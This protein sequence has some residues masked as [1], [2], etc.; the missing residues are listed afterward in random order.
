MKKSAHKFLEFNGKSI[1][2]L[3]NDGVYWV[4]IKP[5]CEALGINYDRQYQNIKADQIL[6]KLYAVQH[7]VDRVQSLRKMVTL[8]EKYIYGWLFSIRSN[9]A[10][11]MNYKEECYEVLFNH[12]HGAITELSKHLQEKQANKERIHF[13]ALQLEE[14]ENFREYQ[15]LQKSV[16]RIDRVISA[17]KKHIENIQLNLFSN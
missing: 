8:P 15:N 14:N 12:F 13:L 1:Y 16:K 2:F 5:I 11:L 17:D 4:A 10:E 7:M 3:N 9:S 6:G